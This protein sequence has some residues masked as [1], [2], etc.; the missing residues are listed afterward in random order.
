VANVEALR[1]STA[2]LTAAATIGD[3]E[4]ALRRVAPEWHFGI[5]PLH[6]LWLPESRNDPRVRAVI[7][8]MTEWGAAQRW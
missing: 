8:V 3:A 2:T 7:D 1:P 4:P 5:V 6:V